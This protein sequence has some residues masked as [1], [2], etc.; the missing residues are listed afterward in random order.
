MPMTAAASSPPPSML[1]HALAHA[2]AG[3]R[4]FPLRPGAKR[5]L[6]SEWQHK[7]TTDEGQIGSWWAEWPDA[8]IGWHT[9]GYLA[10]DVDVKDGKP[11]AESW[12]SLEMLHALP[13]HPVVVT[14]TG[15]S[16]HIFY[17]GPDAGLANVVDS[18]KSNCPLGRGI[19]IR[20][21]G[22]FLVAA[23]SMVDGVRYRWT[24]ELEAAPAAP[25][26]ILDLCPRR[27][28]KAAS[29]SV[30]PGVVDAVT[31]IAASQ[32][33][34][35]HDADPAIEGQGGDITTYKMVCRIRELGVSE[36][37][38]LSLLVQFYNP[39]CEPPWDDD[40]LI[41]ICSSAYRNA[42]NG[43]GSA[44][45]DNQFTA[46]PEPTPRANDMDA[47]LG[48]AN[49]A[50][51]DV[52][53]ED[54]LFDPTGLDGVEIPAQ[55]WLVQDWLP[56]GYV[57]ALYGD[58]GVGKTL[59]AQQLAT[60]TAAGKPWLGLDVMKCRTMALFCE[61]A[62]D[63]LHRRQDAINKSLFMS[64]ADLAG[65]FRWSSRVGKDNT[66]CVFDSKHQL[67]ATPLLKR[68]VAAIRE[69]QPQ[70]L[71]VDTA[72]DTFGG[73]EN[74]RIEVRRYIALLG[75]LAQLM[76]EWGGGAV[77][78]CAHPSRTGITSG[79]GDGGNTAWN[80]TVRSRLYL[81][82]PDD[83]NA[84]PNARVLTRKKSNYA[85]IDEAITLRWND[86]TLS[87][88][89]D[90]L[91]DL[92]DTPTDNAERSALARRVFLAA[93]DN[94]YIDRIPLSK[95]ARAPSYAPRVIAQ[96]P[97]AAG[98]SV[99]DLER[100]MQGVDDLLV[101]K[102]FAFRGQNRHWQQSLVRKDMPF[103]F[104]TKHDCAAV[105]SGPVTETQELLS[106]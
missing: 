100:A 2:R 95:K 58:G 80:N 9:F 91:P 101:V 57:T 64:F 68:I 8:N 53:V 5:P 16:H 102:D 43:L 36:S 97:I 60:A 37:M 78:L 27:S 38:A 59:L 94:C 17:V 32:Y 62:T 15:G 52:G 105:R 31:N 96:Q 76:E 69:F 89:A 98:L 46:I 35:E 85:S 23:G 26:S 54:L 82:R 106:D 29:V 13:P 66:L 40:D 104:N 71:I 75:A 44:S 24:V 74:T 22:G 70:L 48:A 20:T 83:E 30:L 4:V 47:V 21:D 86:G 3:R 65:D 42:Q 77:L 45:P 67:Q 87:P 1:D 99:Q 49:A 18:D 81:S 19:D 33:F 79:R 90:P 39:R 10:V 41:R 93:L 28:R 61:D 25:Q 84:D 92:A 55:R 88:H 11:G 12:A 51:E 103:S 56:V 63:E 14:P 72:A 7:A 6:I 50:A 34:L 73:D